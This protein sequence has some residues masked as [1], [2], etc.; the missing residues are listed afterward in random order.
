MTEKGESFFGSTHS[1]CHCHTA[2]RVGMRMAVG[3]GP[4]LRL[5][6][7]FGAFE[8]EGSLFPR[9]SAWAAI[10]RPLGA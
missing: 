7:P 5:G 8:I 1:G 2:I 4:E 3:T 9:L 6:R 10:V